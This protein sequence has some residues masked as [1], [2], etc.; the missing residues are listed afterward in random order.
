MKKLIAGSLIAVCLTLLAF[1]IPA[2]AGTVTITSGPTLTPETAF[3][4]N[5]FTVTVVHNPP[6]VTG[7]QLQ[8]SGGATVVPPSSN[9]ASVSIGGDFSANVGDIA[10]VAY[11]VTMES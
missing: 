1:A 3:T 11:A 5:N 4:N 10:S 8:G 6:G 2:N 7:D 9:S